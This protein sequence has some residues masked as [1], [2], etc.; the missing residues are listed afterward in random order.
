[1]AGHP[2]DST[3]WG[4]QLLAELH[5]AM[6]NPGTLRSIRGKLPRNYRPA[7]RVPPS[8]YFGAREATISSKHGSPRKGSQN[9][10]S[11]NSP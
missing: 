10:I 1:M 4:E 6:Q 5:L 11:F 9:G 7:A 8:D 3:V 2:A